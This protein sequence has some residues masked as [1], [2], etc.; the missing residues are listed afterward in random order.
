VWA[1][2][3]IF[4]IYFGHHVA[5]KESFYDFIS[6]M[7][8]AHKLSAKE[9]DLISKIEYKPAGSHT[10]KERGAGGCKKEFQEAKKILNQKK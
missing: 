2:G 1:K 10:K 9:F 5:G 3:H 4:N 7:G 6:E 8:Q